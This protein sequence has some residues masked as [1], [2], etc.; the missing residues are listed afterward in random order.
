MPELDISTL[1]PPSGRHLALHALTTQA[2][3]GSRTGTGNAF[4][5]HPWSGMDMVTVNTKPTTGGFALSEFQTFRLLVNNRV[6]SYKGVA[7]FPTGGDYANDFSEGNGALIAVDVDNDGDLD[8]VVGNQHGDKG[9]ELLINS[10]GDGTYVASGSFPGPD[11]TTAV[12]AA[13]VDGD[14]GKPHI[15]PVL[16][17]RGWEPCLR[18]C[19]ATADCLQKLEVLPL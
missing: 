14:G 18:C 19:S 9:C 10:D 12:A 1:S 2:S 4:A 3:I 15:P 11:L 8:L 16:R 6:Y 7:S 13:D 17:K 5:S